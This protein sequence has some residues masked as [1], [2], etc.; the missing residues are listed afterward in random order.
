MRFQHWFA[1]L[2]LLASLIEVPAANADYFISLRAS[3]DTNPDDGNPDVPSGTIFRVT[4]SG[5]ANPVTF[6]DPS[7]LDGPAGLAILNNELYVANT[8]NDEIVKYSIFSPVATLGTSVVDSSDGLNQPTSLR[9]DSA[10]N[11]YAANSGFYAGGN[12]LPGT[13]VSKIT[14]SPSPSAASFGSGHDGPNGISIDDVGNVYVSEFN[15]AL[16][17]GTAVR[18]FDPSGNDITDP[19]PPQGTPG[20]A[21]TAFNNGILLIPGLFGDTVYQYDLTTKTTSPLFSFA[22]F[23]GDPGDLFGIYD[24]GFIF[25]SVIHTVDDDTILVGAS[26]IGIVFKYDY[27]TA[28]SPLGALSYFAVLGGGLTAIGD[29]I[30][31]PEPSGLTLFGIGMVAILKM[32]RR[33]QK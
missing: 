27:P 16:A 11:L 22:A 28:G 3:V 31:V 1:T 4:D 2:V 33:R 14:L 15:E 5:V 8:F 32:R 10:N 21:G 7:S 20:S 23:A 30:E 25:P 9:F 12:V 13:T 19:S 6:I 26:A 18:T 29:I 24:S 17:G